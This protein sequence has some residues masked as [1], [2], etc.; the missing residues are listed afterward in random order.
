MHR[1]EY[2]LEG[3]ACEVVDTDDSGLSG[4][5]NEHYRADQNAC[6]AALAVSAG[7][8]EALISRVREADR[9][10]L[11]WRVVRRAAWNLRAQLN[12]AERAWVAIEEDERLAAELWPKQQLKTSTS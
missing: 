11:R 5:H 7:V 8:L 12:E 10:E 4:L 1:A 9:L 3:S 2:G 6:T